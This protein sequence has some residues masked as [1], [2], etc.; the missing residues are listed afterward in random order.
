VDMAHSLSIMLT[1]VRTRSKNLHRFGLSDS[2]QVSSSVLRRGN[3]QYSRS[4]SESVDY[5]CCCRGWVI[6][7]KGNVCD[8]RLT[9]NLRCS[10]FSCS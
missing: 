9:T 4:S 2:M 8:R 5:C 3:E 7:T 6:R 10:L 1:P